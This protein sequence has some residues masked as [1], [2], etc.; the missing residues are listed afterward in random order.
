MTVWV[1]HHRCLQVQRVAGVCR[2]GPCGT[3]YVN[4]PAIRSDK[5]F[6]AAAVAL[7]DVVV[8]F[9]IHLETV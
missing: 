5:N 6:I 1:T 7:K 2:Q 8:A 3:V 4:H 9:V